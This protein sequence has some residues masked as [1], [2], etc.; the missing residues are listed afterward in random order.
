MWAGRGS[1][2]AR[3]RRGR[4]RSMEL[5]SVASYSVSVLFWIKGLCFRMVLI[6]SVFL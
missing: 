3:G 5:I 1:V 4:G 2:T 6:S